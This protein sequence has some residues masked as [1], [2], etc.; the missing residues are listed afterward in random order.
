M[1]M[2]EVAVRDLRNHGGEILDRVAGGESLTVT[3][4]GRA[5][6]ELRPLRRRPLPAALLLE[7]WRRLPAVD[8]ARL[9]ADIDSVL[10]PAL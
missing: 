4:D 3:R 5:V 2:T 10:D 1:I 8:P 6:A 7:R 9:R